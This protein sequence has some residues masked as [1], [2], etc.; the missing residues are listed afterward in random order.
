MIKMNA[1]M[2]ELRF[3]LKEVTISEGQL[4]LSG[5]TRANK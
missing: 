1:P 5:T 4:K 3:D 2:E